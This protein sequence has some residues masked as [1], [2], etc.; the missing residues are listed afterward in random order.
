MGRPISDW[1]IDV[2]YS[3]PEARGIPEEMYE[4]QTIAIGRT[5]YQISTFKAVRF[6]CQE[7]GRSCYHNECPYV[8]AVR[9]NERSFAVREVDMMWC[10]RGKRS[11]KLHNRSRLVVKLTL[12]QQRRCLAPV[13]AEG[14][15]LVRNL[16]RRFT[17]FSY[18]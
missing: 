18:M 5:R 3:R 9:L 11:L 8:R 10:G 16:Y 1:V 13:K 7:F 17:S 6:N 12:T 15:I 14:L 2:C 4:K